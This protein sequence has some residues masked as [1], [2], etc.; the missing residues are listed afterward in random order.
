MAKTN[1]LMKD[2]I[3]P[4]VLKEL[5]ANIKKNYKSFDDKGFCSSVSKE[6]KKL[7]LKERISLVTHSL[8]DYLPGQF[9]KAVAILLKSLPEELPN[10]SKDI[11]GYGSNMLDSLHGFIMI[12]LTNYVAEYGIANYEVSMNALKIMTSRFSAEEAARYFIQKYP[13]KTFKTYKKWCLD[14]NMHV[15]RLVS[16]STRPRLPWTMQLPEFI[17][18]PTPVLP[19]LELLKN[20]KELYVRRS[21]ANN[22]ND[23]SKDNPDVVI[24]L[25]KKWSKDKS[26]EMQWLVKHA[27]RTL[28]KEGNSEALSIIGFHPDPAIKVQNLTLDSSTVNFGDSLIFK[29][30]IKSLSDS[31]QWLMIDHVIHHMKANGKLSPKVFKLKKIKL[32]AHET[33]E[34]NKSHPIKKITTR[35]YYAGKHEVQLQINGSRFPKKFFSLVI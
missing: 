3:N 35:E 19:F 8:N 1:F 24:K 13:L 32:K 28:I 22:L 31:D 2:S 17:E 20:D 11:E 15:R 4:R 6:L 5:A 12:S 9:E 23:I 33:I 34:I 25:L 21:V 10:G 7:E 27:L 14:E 18:D 29:T 26:S 30:K 16:E